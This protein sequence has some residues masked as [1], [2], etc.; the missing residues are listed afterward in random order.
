MDY[1]SCSRSSIEVDVDPD[2]GQRNCWA[3]IGIAADH[4]FAVTSASLSISTVDHIDWRKIETG[5]TKTAWR[6]INAI[7]L[8]F[9][10]LDKY[11]ALTYLLVH[12]LQKHSNFFLHG[13][14]WRKPRLM[15]KINERWK[16]L[17]REC[18]SN[19]YDVSAWHL[20]ILQRDQWVLGEMTSRN[21]GSTGTLK[22]HVNWRIV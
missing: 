18:K 8:Q 4:I 1:A 12:V 15:W 3:T 11:V 20:W 7:V 21:N 13:G 10:C 17:K 19:I 2:C 9:S 5:Q 16:Q 14:R 22:G 6:I